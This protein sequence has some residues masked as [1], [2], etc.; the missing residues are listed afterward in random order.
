MSAKEGRL[1]NKEEQLGYVAKRNDVEKRS[2]LK[3]NRRGLSRFLRRGWFTGKGGL[4]I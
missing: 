4:K 2:V 1:E 3:G